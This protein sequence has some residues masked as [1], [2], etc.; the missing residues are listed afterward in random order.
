MSV[1]LEEWRGLS[2]WALD[3]IESVQTIIEGDLRGRRILR[4]QVNYAYAALI[5]AHFQRYCREVHSEVT[6]ALVAASRPPALAAVLEDLLTEG[7]LLDRGNPTPGNL[8]RDFGRFGFN[9]WEAVDA[10]DRGNGMRRQQLEQLCDWRNGIVHGDIPG[11]RAS[12]RLVPL[13]LTVDTCQAWR[14]ALGELAGSIDRVVS[15]QCQNLGR[16]RP[17]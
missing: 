17:W 12:G 9:L 11:K 15:K 8:A 3:E 16:S 4:R 5:L 10:D 2:S 6:A 1:A 14:R 7:R 13:D